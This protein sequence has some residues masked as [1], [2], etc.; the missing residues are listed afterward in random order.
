MEDAEVSKSIDYTPV[1]LWELLLIRVALWLLTH[2]PLRLKTDI[3]QEPG[4]GH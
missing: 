2:I 4:R 1:E 3:V